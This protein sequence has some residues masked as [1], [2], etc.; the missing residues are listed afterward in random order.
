MQRDAEAEIHSEVVARTDGR[1]KCGNHVPMRPRWE[2]GSV[3]AREK[4]GNPTGCRLGGER[5]RASRTSGTPQAPPTTPRLL[6]LDRSAKIHLRRDCCESPTGLLILF[7]PVVPRPEVAAF[8][9]PIAAVSRG[10]E[11]NNVDIVEC[12]G[13]LY[14]SN[15][16]KN[17]FFGLPVRAVSVETT[18]VNTQF[19]RCRKMVRFSRASS[20]CI[21]TVCE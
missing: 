10:R 11:V 21:T 13:K 18:S 20:S 15:F 6:R 12:Q 17:F 14:F 5:S 7:A 3:W 16:Y 4:K 8:F 2:C 9:I 19:Y 1:A